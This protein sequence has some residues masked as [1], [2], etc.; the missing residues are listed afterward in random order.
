M[1]IFKYKKWFLLVSVSSLFL[2]KDL[3]YPQLS[4]ALPFNQDMVNN[5]YTLGLIMR[6]KPEGSVSISEAKRYVGKREDGAKLSN[7]IPVTRASLIHGRRA[8]NSNCSPCHGKFIGSKYIPG[9]VGSKLGA[10]NLT[11]DYLKVMPDSHFFQF[12]HFGGMAIMPVYGWKLSIE[13]HWDIVNYIRSVQ[14]GN[15]LL[16]RSDNQKSSATD[17]KTDNGTTTQKAG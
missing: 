8:Y 9:P 12:V 14:K 2:I 1:N 6:S 5:Q 3:F 16:R 7:P 17:L 13:E 10:V 4:F 11:L 15:S